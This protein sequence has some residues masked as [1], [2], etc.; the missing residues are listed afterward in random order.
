MII[1]YWK[2]VFV[3]DT[4]DEKGALKKAGFE[5][6]EPS[7]CD[8]KRERCKA[9]RAG[10]GR[11]FWSD[12]LESATRLKAFCN[13]RALMVMKEHLARLE[14]SRAVDADLVIP[15]KSGRQYLGYQKA[16][17]AY[18][19]QRKHTLIAD[20]PGLGKTIQALGFINYQKPKSVLIVCPATIIF[21]WKD[22]AL[23]WL[24]GDYEIWL[25]KTKSDEIPA[26]DGL[27]VITNYEKLT[28]DSRLSASLSRPWDVAVFDECHLLKNPESMRSRAV[29]GDGR[30]LSYCK[31]ALFLSG[32]PAENY[33]REIWPIAAAIAPAKFGNKLNFESRYCGRHQEYRD[34]SPVWVTTGASHLGELQQRLRA[35]FMVRRLKKDVLPELP[36]KRRQL[37]QLDEHSVD[38][39]KHPQFQ[40]WQEIF[41]Q[42][43][44]AAKAKIEEAK[45]E[46]EY[47]DAVLLLEK[48]TGIA[49]Q[50]MSEFR[51]QSALVKLPLCLKYLD[52]LL[53]SGVENVVIFAYHSDI[54][55]AL[56]NHFKGDCAVISGD[57]PMHKRKDSVSAFQEKR[58]RVFIGQI[59][60]AGVG[61]TLTA[62]N[63][64]VFVEIDWVPTVMSQAEDRLCRIGQ[65]K[66]VHVIHLVLAGTLDANMA[67]KIIEKQAVLE[68]MLDQ[69]PDLKLK[70][71]K[72]G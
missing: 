11:R 45:T 4:L 1:T 18:A 54:I 70:K 46:A 67:Q 38:W 37:I 29:L 30:L 72:E 35:S 56:A 59:R 23:N 22:E 48:L 16:G 21:N 69:Q 52:E 57:T 19:L 13:P 14:R 47:Q 3:C 60:A 15:A 20:Q 65:K 71:K 68:K 25:V 43:Y 50:E 42:R 63:T 44:E 6:H 62:G 51:H 32:T 64:V 55:E 27:F 12:K 5:L 66:M 33:P 41:L 24:V 61:I 40:K 7:I 31:R 39:K 58:V 2:G 8:L 34:G 17:I 36:P 9:C 49:F 28:G 53:D 26:R 10:V